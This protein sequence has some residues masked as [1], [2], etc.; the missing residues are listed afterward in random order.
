MIDSY[1]DL[2]TGSVLVLLRARDTQ[3]TSW[4]GDLVW[5]IYYELLGFVLFDYCQLG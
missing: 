1:T 4:L 2:V 3:Q 5:L